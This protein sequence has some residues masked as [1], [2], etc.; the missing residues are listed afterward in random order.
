VLGG[1]FIKRALGDGVP[2]RERGA[3]LMAARG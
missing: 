2:A 3:A 1:G